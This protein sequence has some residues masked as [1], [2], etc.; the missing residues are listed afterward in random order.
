MTYKRILLS[1]RYVVRT[2]KVENVP[3]ETA[4]TAYDLR[5]LLEFVVI[6]YRPVCLFEIVKCAAHK[7]SYVLISGLDV[8]H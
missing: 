5:E 4:I 1:F 2:F 8:Q 6:Q 3:V 7:L